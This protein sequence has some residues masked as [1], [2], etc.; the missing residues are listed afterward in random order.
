MATIDRPSSAV[1]FAQTART[2]GSAVASA[3]RPSGPRCGGAWP[4]LLF[5]AVGAVSYWVRGSLSTSGV[6]YLASSKRFSSD[7]LIKVCRALDKQRIAYRVD[8]RSGE[9]KSRPTSSIRQPS[10]SRSSTWVSADRRDPR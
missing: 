9:S 10:W 7:D 3:W 2:V 4:R 1:R 8:E 5:L 6:R